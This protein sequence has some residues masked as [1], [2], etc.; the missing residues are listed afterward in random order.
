MSLGLPELSGETLADQ[1]YGALREAIMS[2]QLARGSKITERALA[3]RMGVSPTPVREAIRRLEQDKLIVRTGL[4]SVQVAEFSA[5]TLAEISLIESHLRAVAARL[6]A[7]N[8]NEHDLHTMQTFLEQ[9]EAER[10]RVER[11]KGEDAATQAAG[12][13]RVLELLRQFHRAVD[14]AS[15]NH[16]LMSFLGMAE[17]FKPA[18]R[19]RVLRE[20]IEGN[21]ANVGE[22]FSQHR[23]IF[24]AIAARDEDGV[25]RLTFEHSVSGA[26]A[27]IAR[28]RRTEA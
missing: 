1:A 13:A 14:A 24:E 21:E 10:T 2:G 23:A 5:D 17:A 12:A 7:R 26:A 27:L 25:E 28:R 20:Q 9:A 11:L 4:R 19:E 22:R 3:E 6:A 18:D 8:A 15:H 16:V